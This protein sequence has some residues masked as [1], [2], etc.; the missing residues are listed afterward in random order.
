MNTK[1]IIVTGA[2]QGIGAGIVRAF[3]ERGYNVVG[4]ARH[5]T[6]S[7]EL[8]PSDNLALVDGDIGLSETAKKIAELAGEKSG[9]IPPAER[10]A[11]K[12]FAGWP[13]LDRRRPW[14]RGCLFGRSSSSNRGGAARGRWCACWQMV[15][16]D[17][18]NS[19]TAEQRLKELGIKLPAPPEPF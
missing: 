4:T 9:S 8:S 5:A 13:D 18:S 3:L 14:Q 17:N 7:K 12:T 15:N 16:R 10:C 6:K 2:S 1:T 11:S 19:A